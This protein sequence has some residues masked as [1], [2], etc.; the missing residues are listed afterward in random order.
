M[1]VRACPDSRLRGNDGRRCGDDVM[2][3]GSDVMCVWDDVMG[4]GASLVGSLM[5]FGG[6]HSIV[7]D[8]SSL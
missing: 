6:C 3:G 7:R 1:V 2:C 5:Y 8:L 4:G